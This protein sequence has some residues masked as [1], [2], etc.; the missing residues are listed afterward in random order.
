MTIKLKLRNNRHKNGKSILVFLVREGER[1][2]EISTG[3]A[4]LTSQWDGKNFIYTDNS[5]ESL[6]LD[7]L[8]DKKI[9]ILKSATH[10]SIVDEWGISEVKKFI[11]SNGKRNLER[12]S[13][14]DSAK[15]MINRN[16][17]IK[18]FGNAESYRTAYNRISKYNFNRPLSF[19]DINYTFLRNWKDELIRDGLSLNTI[20]AY[21]RAVRAIFNEAIREKIISRDL[22]PFD[23]GK[24]LIPKS[25]RSKDIGLTSEQ[26]KQVRDLDLV[27]GSS[28]S[29]ARD[30]FLLGF[31]LRGLDFMDIVLLRTS[32]IVGGRL[33]LKSRNKLR[34]REDGKPIS[35]KLYP[36]ANRIINYYID[37][38]EDEFIFDFIKEHPDSNETAAKYYINKRG[39]Y[40]KL[41]KELGKRI[42]AEFNLTTKVMRHTFSSIG[43]NERKVDREIIQE[44]IGHSRGEVVYSYINKYS[45]GELD[46]EHF[47]IINI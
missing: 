1:K 18:H 29:L 27:K 42:G 6:E 47:K 13:F 22:Y 19:E 4:L 25:Q 24:S 11:K 37:K 8:I 28:L 15:R 26:V 12:V 34:N 32:D 3:I 5:K 23:K 33:E 14:D 40:I 31:Y 16:V 36:E 21:L 10:N 17:I 46:L 9:R 20:G 7:I 45:K 2:V 43:R 44:L 35:I 38:R 30:I 41:F 39:R